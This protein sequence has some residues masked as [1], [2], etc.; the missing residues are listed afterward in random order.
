MALR[1][2]LVAQPHLYM[3]DTQGRPLDAGKVYFG[4][5]DKDPELYPINVFYDEALTIAAPQ[6]IRTMGGFMNANGQMVEIYAAETE[7][8]VKVLDGYGRQ[9][10]YQESMSSEN[11]QLAA[12]KLDTGIT[13][14][15]KFGGVSRL[16]SSKLSDVV[17][18][19]DFGASGDGTNDANAF[20]LAANTGRQ[21]I[22]PDGKYVAELED[23]SQVNSV[24]DAVQRMH[25]QCE[26]LEI[27]LPAEQIDVTTSTVI[28]AT[29]SDRLK[30]IGAKPF[31]TTLTSIGSVTG[32][33]GNWS[34][35]ASVSDATGITVGDTILVGDVSPGVKIPGTYNSRPPKGQL[36]LQFFQNGT[37]STSERNVTVS[38]DELKFVENGDFIIADGSVKRITSI[39]GNSGMF[40]LAVM[41]K[42]DIFNKQYWYS[43]Q[44]SNLGIVSISGTTVT[45]SV[46]AFDSKANIG[47]IIAIQNHGISQIVSI[48]SPTQ[49]TISKAIG[50][51]TSPLMPWGV[52]VAGEIHEGAWVVSQVSG[53]SVTWVNTSHTPY[54]P[55]KN[56]ITSA[57]LTALKSN[58]IYNTSGFIVN[59]VLNIE[60][61]GIQGTGSTSTVG[62]DLRGVGT[63]R[64]G[65]A[66]LNSKT[67]I[68][69]FGYGSWLSSG[70]VLQASGSYYGGQKTRGINIAGGEARI[71]SATVVGTDGIGVFIGEGA[72]ARMS[73]TRVN[74]CK[75]N[76]VRMEVGGSAWGDFSIIGHNQSDGILVVGGVN[77][78]FVGCRSFCGG[79]TAFKG[80]NGGYGRMTGMTALCNKS[81][82]YDFYMGQWEANQSI[83]MGNGIGA[84]LSRGNYS[85][86]EAGIGFNSTGIYALTVSN[87]TAT[88]GV[89]L[90][91]HTTAMLVDNLSTVLAPDTAFSNN[92][93]DVT[94]SN[95]SRV[96]I[97]GQVGAETFSPSLNTAEN[98]G[99]LISDE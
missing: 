31:E 8:S 61:V 28:S 98:N 58:L 60:S 62:I 91:N 13:A 22:I 27:R 47:D 79:N 10:Y 59:E 95:G 38:N 52:I 72:Y 6:P 86:E 66:V 4:E 81:R 1:T 15:A 41:P 90:Y 5:P 50:D 12:Q 75:V 29:G 82:G 18:I 23:A 64:S 55:P 77:F 53:N 44:S 73:D 69:G 43:M 20:V 30:I 2:S 88:S 71:G 35:T 33:A 63:L 39:S 57:K 25:L 93:N 26:S 54:A 89:S 87:V 24:L 65:K 21:L 83:L 80:Q 16:L 7:Y 51:I 96:R 34:V 19:K 94:A 46:A 99:T 11:A 78:H 56:L 3:G 48:E 42:K 49:L 70:A 37:L 85:L 67:G 17:S 68:N 32:E 40:D 36:Q 92:V 84:V 76:G 14:T 74:A 9:V 97:A 45:C